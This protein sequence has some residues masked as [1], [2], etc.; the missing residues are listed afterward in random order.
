MKKDMIMKSK[1]YSGGKGLAIKEREERGFVFR[2]VFSLDIRF[3]FFS[4]FLSI[5]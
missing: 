2:V 3:G 1:I 4:F 5:N